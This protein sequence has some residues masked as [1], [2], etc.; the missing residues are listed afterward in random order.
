M[1]QRQRGLDERAQQTEAL[2]RIDARL[3]ALKQVQASV[4]ANSKLDPWLRAQGLD[5]LPR[6]F[7]KLVVEPGWETAFESVLQDRVQG[8]EVGRLDTVGGL[9]ADAPPARVTF[10]STAGAVG[11]GSD[12]AETSSPGPGFRK[13]RDLVRTHDAAFSAL[14]SI[15]LPMC[16]WPTT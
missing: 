5:G 13:M 10:Y 11:R 6:L 12:T 4:E 9:A 14:L 8:V 3:Q 15:G 7:R 16:S 2:G 1:E